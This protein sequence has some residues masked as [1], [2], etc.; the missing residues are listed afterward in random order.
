MSTQELKDYKGP[1]HYIS[2]R[3]VM[4][5]DSETTPCRIVF[6]ASATY[7]GHRLNDYWAKGPD[8]MNSLFG[9]LLRFREESVAI[10]GDIKRCITW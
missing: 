9:V 3:K 4:K 6:D 8:M 1:F 10:V 5:P 7:K 2:H